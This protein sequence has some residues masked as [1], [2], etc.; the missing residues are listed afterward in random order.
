MIFSYVGLASQI[1]RKCEKCGNDE[2]E[3][4]RKQVIDKLSALLSSLTLI[5][6]NTGVSHL[7]F[8]RH[9]F[10]PSWYLT[11]CRWDRQM[12]GRPHFWHVPNAGTL[13]RKTNCTDFSDYYAILR[14]RGVLCRVVMF[15]LLS[16]LFQVCAT[17]HGVSGM[18]FLEFQWT[19]FSCCYQADSAHSLLMGS[20]MKITPV[21][22]LEATISF[23]LL[24]G[25]IQFK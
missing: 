4:T 6:P 12:K 1:T 22:C 18:S 10:I 21:L 25:Y 7:P 14:S 23:F 19:N 3:Y 11:R 13:L 2:F 15:T 16:F 5:F 24:Y 9:S 20:L 17:P 8:S